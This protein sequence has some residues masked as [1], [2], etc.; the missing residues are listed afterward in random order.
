MIRIQRMIGTE[1]GKYYVFTGASI[2]ANDAQSLGLFHSV[3]EPGDIESSI[4]Q[5]L[6]ENT[7]D[8]YQPKQIPDK[9]AEIAS[10]FAAQNIPAALNGSD[11]TGISN[12]LNDKLKKILGRKSAIALKMANDVM[13]AQIPLSL[14]DAVEYELDQLDTLFRTA[15]A[16]EGLTS[17]VE[18]RKPQFKGHK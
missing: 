7:H 17:A 8:K 1:L 5:I 9:F 15:D 4:R 10:A 18:H 13:D 14:A 6:T 12:A 11:L 2:P 3:V 16:L